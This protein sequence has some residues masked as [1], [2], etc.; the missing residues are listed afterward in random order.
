MP[1]GE[2][3][4]FEH[5]PGGADFASKSVLSWHCSVLSNQTPDE[6]YFGW[7]EAEMARLSAGGWVTEVVGVDDAKFQLFDSYALS[8]MHWA[9]KEF[10]GLSS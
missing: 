8:Y 7:K 10:S 1:V 2:K 6:E 5:V 3:Y 4:G 9:Y